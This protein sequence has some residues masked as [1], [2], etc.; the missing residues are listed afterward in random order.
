MRFVWMGA[1][2]L[3]LVVVCA[4]LAMVAA[5]DNRPGVSA[6]A[7]AHWPETTGLDRS[8]PVPTL[9]M[10]VHPRCACSRASIAELAELMAR[11]TARPR[12]YVA[13]VKP[14]GLP[15]D[16][17]VTGIRE[18]AM[19]IPGVK[20]VRDLDGLEARAFAAQTS[21]QTYLYGSDG[22]LIFSGGITASRGHAGENIG[23]TAILSLL[24]DQPAAIRTSS[25]FGCSL[26]SPADQRWSDESAEAAR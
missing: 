18:A 10:I 6:D 8:G 24:N 14:N 15:E 26:T 20:V 19:R 21:G 17:D 9:V 5:Y 12:A 25:V 3:W 13:I 23:R 11:T 16:W 2:A 7:P 1:L 22:R 4:G